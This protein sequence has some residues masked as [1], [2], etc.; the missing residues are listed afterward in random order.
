[1]GLNTT[2]IALGGNLGDVQDNFIAARD[3]LMTSGCILL[4]SSK[5][6]QT[7]PIGPAEQPDYLNA[8]I[9]I[10]TSLSPEQL[11][12]GLHNIENNHGRIR[13]EHWGARTLDLDLLDY[14]N[15]ITHSATLTLPHP[16]IQERNFVLRPLC[17]INPNWQHPLL[18]Q[19]A[20][21]LLANL[22]DQGEQALPEGVSW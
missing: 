22:L 5:I 6:Y 16:R 10:Q 9:E 15:T 7:S 14:E 4:Q 18:K 3:D 13:K 11:L 8:V 2:L 19:S 17:D 20:Q 12:A 21:E 1:M